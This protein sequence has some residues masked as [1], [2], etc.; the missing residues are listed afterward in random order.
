[1]RNTWEP[2]LGGCQKGSLD[3]DAPELEKDHVYS[4]QEKAADR[5]LG[6]LRINDIGAVEPAGV[7]C[8]CWLWAA[9]S[10]V[11]AMTSHKQCAHDI[12]PGQIGAARHPV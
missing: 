7:N 8:E 3:R 4:M 9:T 11:S 10:F 1:M 2:K 5:N 12:A 6:H